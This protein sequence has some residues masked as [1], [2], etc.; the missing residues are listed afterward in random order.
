MF[1][2][3]S[4]G[5]VLASLQALYMSPLF[6]PPSPRVIPCEVDKKEAHLAD[7]TKRYDFGLGRVSLA[8]CPDLRDFELTFS[9]LSWTKFFLVSVYLF[10]Y[11]H[12]IVFRFQ[13]FSI[14][15]YLIKFD[16][17]SLESGHH[18]Q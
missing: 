5:N 18:L 6:C 9:P 17:K 13:K 2:L 15:V 11:A 16:T 4:E 7:C 8:L 12:C 1:H 3:C 10:T 14:K